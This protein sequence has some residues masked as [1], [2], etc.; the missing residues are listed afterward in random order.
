MSTTN[1]TS[2]SQFAASVMAFPSTIPAV[3]RFSVE[4]YHRMIEAGILGENDRVELVDG[5]IVEMS[6][7]GPSHATCVSLLASAL[8]DLL[9]PGWIVRVQSPI[10]LPNGEPEPDIA[11]VKGNV[12][13]YRD[14]HP[15]GPD[16]AIV[17]EVADATLQFDRGQ[18]RNQYAQAGI[19]EYWIVNL[20]DRCVE[21]YKNPARNDYRAP[22][23]VDSAG[24]LELRLRGT[25]IGRISVT[26]ALP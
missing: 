18:K 21:I 25:A 14:H 24:V 10:T 23:I 15:G 19:P 7:I 26:D 9:P 4:E 1:A 5:W 8:Q 2:D 11:V 3:R 22:E 6:P 13:D 20:N 17:V 12:R 16:I